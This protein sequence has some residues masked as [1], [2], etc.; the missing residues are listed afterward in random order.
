MQD[1]SDCFQCINTVSVEEADAFQKCVDNFEI[2]EAGSCTDLMAT[3]CCLAAVSSNSACLGSELFLSYAECFVGTECLPLT[4]IGS[5]SV[6]DNVN[7]AGRLSSPLGV[8]APN[9]VAASAATAVAMLL[10][11]AI[12]ANLQ[13]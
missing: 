1:N 2:D 7:G 9:G 13:V 12:V 8:I 5:R 3:T 4:C 6:D 10:A 11:T